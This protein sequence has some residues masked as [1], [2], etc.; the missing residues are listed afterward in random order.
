MKAVLLFAAVLALA[1]AAN[2]LYLMV[3][4]TETDCAGVPYYMYGY[5]TDTWC[6]SD[7]YDYPSDPTDS[8][9]CYDTDEGTMYLCVDPTTF[10][11]ELWFPDGFVGSAEFT[12]STCDDWTNVYYIY[13]AG[14][15][16]QELSLA[17]WSVL[18]PFSETDG[19]VSGGC[20]VDSVLGYDYGLPY[21]YWASAACADGYDTADE[22]YSVGVS[23]G[24][25]CY[26][27]GVGYAY[28][29]YCGAEELAVGF[30]AL[31]TVAALF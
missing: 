9:A 6:D 24:D 7:Y 27:S 15:S 18:S 5:L 30:G 8:G 19:W 21:V 29:G 11:L 20:Y 2:N 10:D 25:D 4:Y 13:G 1:S 3:S 26:D 12:G 14:S 22:Y 28:Q 31:A 17:D 16:C 23:Y